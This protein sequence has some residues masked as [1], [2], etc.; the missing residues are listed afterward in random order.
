MHCFRHK[1][2]PATLLQISSTCL[3]G[4][5]AVARIT[6]N[7][8]PVLKPRDHERL[9]H[10]EA[11]IDLLQYILNRDQHMRPCLADVVKRT[12]KVYDSV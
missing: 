6:S 8:M 9:G 10:H 5:G 11:V 7:Y 3:Q 2:E 4:L 12:Q 1:Q